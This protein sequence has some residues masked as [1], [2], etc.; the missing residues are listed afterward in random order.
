MIRSTRGAMLDQTSLQL[1]RLSA[2][3][4]A[5]E[6]QATTGLK[7]NRPSDAPA[8]VGEAER[9]HAAVADQGV[10]QAN[11]SAATSVLDTLDSALGNAA[12]IVLRAREIAV[13]GASDTTGTDARA[14]A[15]TE[16]L[17]L[18]DAMRTAANTSTNGRYVFAGTNWDTAAFDDTNT[19]QG[20]TDVPET[21]VGDDRWV[22]TGLDGSAVFGGATDVFGTLTALAAALTADDATAVSDT[23]DDLD[24][25][26]RTLTDARA[27][28]GSHTLAAEDATEVSESLESL[29]STRLGTLVSADPVA[30]YSE[31][32]ELRNTYQSTLQVA[33]SA[34]S[35]TLFD[36][37]R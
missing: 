35:Q 27:E 32:S 6:E 15:A 4:G 31:L 28:V 12:D 25:A 18:V 30:V 16:V 29:F 9:M 8:S 24:A 2:R 17:G 22:Q 33:G 20:N 36:L 26:T 13:A 5:V 14:A 10:W 19:Y 21:R 11:A 37:L 23:L 34:S 3:M 1:A 7:L